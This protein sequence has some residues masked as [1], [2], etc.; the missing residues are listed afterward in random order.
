[1]SISDEETSKSVVDISPTIEFV[2][3]HHSVMILHLF[4]GAF[5]LGFSV[6]SFLISALLYM[7][8]RTTGDYNRITDN[9]CSKLNNSDHQPLASSKNE[10]S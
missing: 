2:R 7:Q 6:R 3:G 4:C 10:L 5:L 8:L 9:M 1:M